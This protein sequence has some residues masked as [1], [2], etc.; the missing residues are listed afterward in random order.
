MQIILD[1]GVEWCFTA[2]CILGYIKFSSDKET[3]ETV[4]SWIANQEKLSF[5][6]YLAN[7]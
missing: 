7:N 6:K 5:E 2:F 3:V 4:E 1:R